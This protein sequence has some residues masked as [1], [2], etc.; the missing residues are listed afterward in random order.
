MFALAEWMIAGR[1]LRPRRQEGIV[2]VI[3]LASFLGIALGVAVLI[4]VLS[5]MGGFRTE[6]LGRILGFNAH[7]SVLAA[8]GPLVD[9]APVVD[10]VRAIDGVASVTPLVEG[11]VMATNR[12]RATGA[13]VRG[14]AA[15][16]L[17]ARD[18]IVAGTPTEVLDDFANGDGILLG[19]Q[20]A[21]RLGVA[22]GE[23]VTLISPRGRTT[24][25]G[26]VP[27]LRAYKVVGTFDAG[28]YQFDNTFLFM[29]LAA[30]QAYFRLG[31]GVS[32]LEIMV[33]EPIAIRALRPAIVGALG[34]GDRLLDWQ[35]ADRG[36]FN[37]LQ[38]EREVMFLILTAIILVAALNIISG[39]TMLVKDKG[40]DIAILR[41]M[42]ASRGMVMRIF[43]IT[44]ASIGVVGTLAGT[45]L[46]FL[47]LDN[48]EAIRQVLQ[49][50]FGFNL[51][52]PEV[53][54]LAQLPS[55]VDWVEVTRVIVMA[56]VLSVLA[57]IYPSWRAARLDP[58]EALRNE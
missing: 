14:I 3:A 23:K 20:L 7:A 9:Y 21:R 4:V 56:L 1:Y 16:D 30:A 53:Y 32:Q 43:F 57:T 27:R 18:A 15:A 58:V 6:V 49:A 48:I 38:T 10:R 39:L 34:T 52:P 35:Q 55:T 46:G 51:F 22:R 37:A 45:G 29:P 5:V 12:G 24:A 28:W 40:A 33:D 41:T 54:G 31:A 26:T 13:I 11:Q 42:G 19:S 36:F 50:I 25:F 17:R 8:S 47:V 44:G 2:S